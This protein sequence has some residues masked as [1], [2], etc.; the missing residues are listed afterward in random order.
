[1]QHKVE[2]YTWKVYF[3]LWILNIKKKKIQYVQV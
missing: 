3:Y 1:M 2:A